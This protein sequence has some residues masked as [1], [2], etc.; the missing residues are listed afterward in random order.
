MKMQDGGIVEKELAKMDTDSDNDAAI[1]KS[2]GAIV[3]DKE[4]N[5]LVE[6]N[7]GY[8]DFAQNKNTMGVIKIAPKAV[9]APENPNEKISA[10]QA[11]I[12]KFAQGAYPK[13]TITEIDE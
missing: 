6:K 8:V 5:E 13:D 3:T 4:R 9:M 1:K 12:L 7:K 10:V 11:N 2:L